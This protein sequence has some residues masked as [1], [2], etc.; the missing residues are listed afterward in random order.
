MPYSSSS[1]SSA[2]STATVVASTTAVVATAATAAILGLVGGYY[3]RSVT[4]FHPR[5][6]ELT[7]PSRKLQHE[8]PTAVL[9][10]DY[11]EELQLAIHLAME[12]TS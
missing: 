9:Q 5:R 7:S 10:S 1:S 11:Q 8:L 6:H 3:Y 4:A 2:S 12:G